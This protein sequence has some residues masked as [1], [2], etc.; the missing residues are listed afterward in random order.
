MDIKKKE[1]LLKKF[2]SEVTVQKERLRSNK[3]EI[4]SLCEE[5]GIDP[6]EATEEYIDSLLKETN[7]AIEQQEKELEGLLKEY[8]ELKATD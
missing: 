4:N 1:E 6:K 5:L 8:E 2:E 3:E 7:D